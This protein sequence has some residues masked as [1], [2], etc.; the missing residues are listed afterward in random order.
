MN[1]R[2]LLLFVVSGFLIVLDQYTK[3]MVSLHMPLNYSMQVVEG[4]FNLTHIRNSGVAFGLFADQQSEYK[5]L[6]FIAIS[7]VAIMAILVIFHQNPP[8]K[9]LVQ[10]G[11]ILIFSGA[12][13]NLIDRV[14]HGEVIDFFDFFI[15]EHHFPAF[16]VADS[17]ITVGVALMVIDL[18]FGKLPSESSSNTV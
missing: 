7:A 13:G 5:A 16:N 17:C 8:D 9:K 4:F 14:L 3:F 15:N 2:Y 10:V 18:F 11:L 1:N 12:I 6:M